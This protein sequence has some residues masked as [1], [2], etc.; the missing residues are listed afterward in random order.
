[1]RSFVALE[2]PEPLRTAL[3]DAQEVVPVGRGVPEE[4]LHVT[5]AFLGDQPDAVLEEL[6]R[7]LDDRPLPACRLK[8]EGVETYGGRIP[9]LIAAE[10]ARDPGLLALHGAVHR[11]ARAAGIDMPRERFRPH[12]TLVRFGSGIRKADRPRLRRALD[13]LAGLATAPVAGEAVTLYR[14]HRTSDGA[15]HDPLARYALGAAPA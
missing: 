4:N 14:S 6:H 11:A 2:V 1:M 3:L 10:L 7:A 5:L 12:V 9:R 15:I 8:V 13:E